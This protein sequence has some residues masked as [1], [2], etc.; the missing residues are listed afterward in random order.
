VSS[1]LNRTKTNLTGVLGNGGNSNEYPA[2]EHSRS[3]LHGEFSTSQL[4]T[5][6]R[7]CDDLGIQQPDYSKYAELRELPPGWQQLLRSMDCL[8]FAI[9]MIGAIALA[10]IH[11]NLE[12]WVTA[13][14]ASAAIAGIVLALGV[15]N[16][17]RSQN[18][19]ETFTN[20]TKKPSELGNARSHQG[21][22]RT[23]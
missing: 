7:E 3:C 10:V 18:H 22:P 6:M 15:V 14:I 17:T 2:Y 8:K 21:K 20:P 16:V 9:V 12:A 1:R 11:Q 19:G 5:H 23:A 4:E 13:L